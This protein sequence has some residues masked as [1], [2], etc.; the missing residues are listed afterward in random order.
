M[1]DENYINSIYEKFSIEDDEV[2][3]N[4]FKEIIKC[5]DA[6]DIIKSEAYCGIGDIINFLAPEISEDLGYKYYKKALEYDENNLYARVGICVIYTSYSAPTDSIFPESEYL[7]HLKIL[8]DEYDNV[9]DDMKQNIF[10]LLK[11]LV[12]HRIRMTKEK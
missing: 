3:I 1:I 12:E 8:V 4:K 5:K 9:D 11:D 7:K 10:Q 2:L 6:S